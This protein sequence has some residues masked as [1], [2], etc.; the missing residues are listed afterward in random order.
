MSASIL[1]YCIK[2]VHVY[3]TPVYNQKIWQF[4]LKHIGQNAC[5]ANRVIGNLA[6]LS[7]LEANP[8]TKPCKFLA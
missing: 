5:Y 3:I 1:F 4:A 8:S 6:D 7:S 2:F